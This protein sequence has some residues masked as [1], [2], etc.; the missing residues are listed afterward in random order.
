MLNSQSPVPLYH[1]LADLLT[2]QIRSGSY[3]KG[4]VIPSETLIAKQYKIGRPTVRQAMDILVRKGLVERKRGSGTFVREQEH[5]VDLFSLAGTSQ[6]FL[7]KGIKTASKILEPVSV[8]KIDDDK[9]NPFNRKRAFFLSRLTL[10]QKDPVLLEDIYLHPE[11]FL[12]IDRLELEN[13]SLSGVV[14]DQYYLEPETARQTFKISFL[15]ET[16]A[17]LLGLLPSD[18]ILEV[19]RTLNFPG[20]KGAI[21]SRLYCRTDT[22]LFSQT[23]NLAMQ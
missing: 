5:Q 11:L 16:K 22:F 8:R 1:Q 15:P 10:V 20:A 7:T 21:F 2:R 6:A 23:M 14:S 3:K 19:Q 4:D 9:N 13:R 12:G 17:G 18:P